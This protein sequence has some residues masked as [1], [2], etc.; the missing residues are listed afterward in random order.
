VV[1]KYIF[2]RQGFGG[3]GETYRELALREF[4]KKE[5]R[6]KQKLHSLWKHRN[7][8]RLSRRKT[9]VPIVAVVGYTNAGKLQ[10]TAIFLGCVFEDSCL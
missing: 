2:R 8:I 5:K 1:S 10:P 4:Q 3:A 9:A 7:Q 6:I